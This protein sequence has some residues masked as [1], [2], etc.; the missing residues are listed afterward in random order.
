MLIRKITVDNSV[1]YFQK[2]KN[3][4]KEIGNQKQQKLVPP[5]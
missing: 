4:K 3:Q 5:P 1:R 2:V